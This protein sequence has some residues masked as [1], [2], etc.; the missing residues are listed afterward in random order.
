M[1]YELVGQISLILF[2]NIGSSRTTWNHWYTWREG[3]LCA[4]ATLLTFCHHVALLNIYVA[5]K[6]LILSDLFNFLCCAVLCCDVPYRTVP[7]RTVPYRTVPHLLYVKPKRKDHMIFTLWYVWLTL[8]STWRICSLEQT[9]K[10]RNSSYLFAAN[11]SA[12]QF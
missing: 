10:S 4:L 11:F 2:I 3:K 8:F 1:H 6:N 9:K 7:C 12:S 5:F